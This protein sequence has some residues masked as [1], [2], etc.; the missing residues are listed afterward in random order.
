MITPDQFR[1]RLRR[2]K[3]PPTDWA[4]WIGSPTAWLALLLSAFSVYGTLV[5][6]TDDIRVVT[7]RKPSAVVQGE[8]VEFWALDQDLILINSGNR[9]AAVT[10]ITLILWFQGGNESVT[11]D[12]NHHQSIYLNYDFSSVVVKPGEMA[13]LT[14]SKFIDYNVPLSK[15][16][17]PV[18]Y[19]VSGGKLTS[20]SFRS[21]PKAGDIMAVCLSFRIILPDGDLRT[22][23]VLL[24]IARA[25]FVMGPRTMYVDDYTE[26]ATAPVVLVRN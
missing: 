11:C 22:A 3:K 4:K 25:P 26:S 13:S 20:A 16:I 10:E 2:P 8:R 23:S 14:L 9:A 5:R 15:G 21:A 7:H 6:K 12:H 19:E 1:E 17:L 18:E 24:E